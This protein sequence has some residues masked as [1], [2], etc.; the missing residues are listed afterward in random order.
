[1]ATNHP[2][3]SITLSQTNYVSSAVTGTDVSPTCYITPSPISCG[4]VSAGQGGIQEKRYESSP[5]TLSGVPPAVGWVFSLTVNARPTV[6]SNIPGS[7]NLVLRA[8]MYPYTLNG[9]QQNTS[10]CYDSSPRFLEPPKSVICTGYEYTYAQFG[11]QS[12]QINGCYSET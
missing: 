10:T 5:I 7:S 3:G 6:L 11:G 9:I 2:I 4:G 12:V 1:L 8:I